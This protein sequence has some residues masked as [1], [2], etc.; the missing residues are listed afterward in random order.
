MILRG[1]MQ[2]FR[3]GCITSENF[4]L[5]QNTRNPPLEDNVDTI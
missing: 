4:N 3:A 5:F 1:E 2:S